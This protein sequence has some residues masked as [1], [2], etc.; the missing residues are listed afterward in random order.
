M[1]PKVHLA[2]LQFGLWLF[3]SL[4]FLCSWGGT[5][6]RWNREEQQ[7]EGEQGWLLA[8]W[9]IHPNLLPTYRSKGLWSRWNRPYVRKNYSTAWP[10]NLSFTPTLPGLIQKFTAPATLVFAHHN[11]TWFQDLKI[12]SSPWSLLCCPQ[13]RMNSVLFHVLM[14][15]SCVMY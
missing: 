8:L 2:L 4:S 14:C 13:V 15:T 10:I 1:I 3:L 5:S 12:P 6:P 9:G 11:L 7:E